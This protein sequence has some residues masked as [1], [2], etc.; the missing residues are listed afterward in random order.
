MKLFTKNLSIVLCLVTL[1]L[2]SAIASGSSKTLAMNSRPFLQFDYYVDLN[3]QEEFYIYLLPNHLYQITCSA[4]FG[5]DATQLDLLYYG[6]DG[7]GESQTVHFGGEFSSEVTLSS[8]ESKFGLF[9]LYLQS[10]QSSGECYIS[11]QK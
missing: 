11:L 8:L 1:L 2:F 4:D 6:R 5:S 3:N 9:E 10:K 7:S